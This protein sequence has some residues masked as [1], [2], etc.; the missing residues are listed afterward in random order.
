MNH[1]RNGRRL[2]ERLSRKIRFSMMFLFMVINAPV[3]TIV[4]YK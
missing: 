2:Y 3:P 4:Q 1:R